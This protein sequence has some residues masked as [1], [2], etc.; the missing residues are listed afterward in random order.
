MRVSEARFYQV[1]TVPDTQGRRNAVTH[2][3]NKHH[4]LWFEYPFLHIQDRV[5]KAKTLATVANICYLVE[6]EANEQAASESDT[7]RV[8]RPTKKSGALAEHKL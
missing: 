3:T 6:E 5:S 2:V 4:D 7:Q 8:K 1:V